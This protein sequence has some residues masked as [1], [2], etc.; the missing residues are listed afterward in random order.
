MDID[1]FIDYLKRKAAEQGTQRQ[2]A[3]SLGVSE[4]YLSDVL[5]GRREPGQKLLDAVGFER[6]A[7]YRRKVT[8]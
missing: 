1:E 4:A 7:L 5:N 2:Y 8:Q 6:V 3:E